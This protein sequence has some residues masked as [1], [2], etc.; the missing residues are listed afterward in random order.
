[1]YRLYVIIN[2]YIWLHTVIICNLM[3]I[4][5]SRYRT[6]SCLNELDLGLFP[7]APLCPKNPQRFAMALYDFNI[8]PTTKLLKYW[9]YTASTA[10]ITTV[11]Q[12]VP[13]ATRWA[14]I[15]RTILEHCRPTRWTRSRLVI[16]K[17]IRRVEFDLDFGLLIHFH[18]QSIR[19]LTPLNF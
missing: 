9:Q 19:L 8:R 14:L 7:S 2:Y 11:S 1:M 18:G 17:R 6:R 3:Y 10:P 15:W 5:I 4:R 12:R 13:S 16:A